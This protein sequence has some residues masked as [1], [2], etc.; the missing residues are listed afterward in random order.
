MKSGDEEEEEDDEEEEDEEE[1]GEEEEERE[2]QFEVSNRVGNFPPLP[3]ENTSNMLSLGL[4]VIFFNILI[5][6]GHSGV[7]SHFVY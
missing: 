1:D 4:F 2:G 6:I 5:F 3:W 7:W